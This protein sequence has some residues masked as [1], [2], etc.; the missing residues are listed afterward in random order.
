MRKGEPKVN[1]GRTPIRRAI[2]PEHANAIASVNFDEVKEDIKKLLT[3]SKD[4]WPADYGTYGP[5]FIRLA[6]HAAGSYRA[7]DGR[8]GSDGGR[9]R[10][11]PERS[12]ADN[13]NLDK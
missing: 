5:F 7:S 6:W 9:Q 3:D 4:F 11:E 10:F 8:G 13:T 12:R 2:T 1:L